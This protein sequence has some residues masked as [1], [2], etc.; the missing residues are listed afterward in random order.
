[1]TTPYRRPHLI[2]AL[3]SAAVVTLTGCASSQNQTDPDNTTSTAPQRIAAI[4][5]DVA[6]AVATLGGGDRLVLIP[7]TQTNPALTNHLPVMQSVTTTLAAHGAADPEQILATRPDLAIITPRHEG[8]SDTTALLEA[9]SVPV[10]TLP[11]SWQTGEQML[12]NITLIGDAIGTPDQAA[13]LVREISDAFEAIEPLTGPSPTVLVLS[14]QAGRPMV[15]AGDG[16]TLDLLTR[17]GGRNAA[18][19]AGLTRTSF[20][21]PEQIVRANPDAILLVDILGTGKDSFA[22]VLTNPAVAELAAVQQD[23]IML[24]GGKQT[25]AF[26]LRS[27]PEGLVQIRDWLADLG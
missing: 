13:E 16:F 8:E 24:L 15:N 14:N 12:N 19:D 20:A 18:A 25:Q 22:S 10:L 2:A 11:N 27:A 3:L 6:E 7:G 5:P 9:S 4:S 23:R 17:A 1:M 26:G 21:D